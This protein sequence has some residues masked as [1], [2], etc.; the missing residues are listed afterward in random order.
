MEIR[1]ANKADIEVVKDII[2]EA[3]ELMRLSNI[4]QWQNPSYPT[5]DILE[6]DIEDR[7]LFVM[8]K[9]GVVIGTA[10]IFV[11]N[12]LDNEDNYQTIFDGE[13]LNDDPYVVI[14]RCAIINN[15]RGNNLIA[16]FFE[17]ARM[18]AIESGIHNLRIDTH[19]KNLSMQKAISKYNFVYCGKVYMLDDTE[20]LAYQLFIE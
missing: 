15:E 2:N 16:K 12:D 7:A 20:R 18:I 14:H 13:W 8:E 17:K 11:R 3:K 10:S 5:K 1:L 9:D 19:E 6:E 4:P